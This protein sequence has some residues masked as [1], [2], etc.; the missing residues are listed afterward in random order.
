MAQQD[1]DIAA[2]VAAYSEAQRKQEAYA[3][4]AHHAEDEVRRAWSNLRADF[5]T[6]LVTGKIIAKGFRMPHT[7]GSAEADIL[8]SEWRVM[9]LDDRKAEAVSKVDGTSM[10]TGI[11]IAK[12]R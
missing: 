6:K 3:R 8:P 5:H 1:R 10:Y 2:E 9:T 12:S 11:V 4:A 7:A